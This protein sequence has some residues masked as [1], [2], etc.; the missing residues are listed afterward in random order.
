MKK[1]IRVSLAVMGFAFGALFMVSC[2]AATKTP[3][4][5]LDD[6]VYECKD[7]KCYLK[8]RNTDNQLGK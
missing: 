2:G 4:T 7:G 5:Y 3:T 1:V 6:S 8:P